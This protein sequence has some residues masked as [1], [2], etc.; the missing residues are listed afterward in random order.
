MT[1]WRFQRKDSSAAVRIPWPTLL[2][3]DSVRTPSSVIILPSP[4]GSASSAHLILTLESRGASTSPTPIERNQNQDGG[5]E[6]ANNGN[7]WHIILPFGWCIPYSFAFDVFYGS[8]D[9][10]RHGRRAPSVSDASLNRTATTC[11]PR[12]YLQVGTSRSCSCC[13]LQEQVRGR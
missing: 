11:P 12:C 7:Q 1:G 4:T 3:G 2:P 10:K 6:N 5:N 9:S 13:R 8:E